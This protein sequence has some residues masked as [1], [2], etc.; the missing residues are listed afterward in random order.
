[1]I[2]KYFALYGP[3]AVKVLIIRFNLLVTF[4]SV[5]TYFID[6]RSCLSSKEGISKEIPPRDGSGL[7]FK[8][9]RPE[10]YAEYLVI[11]GK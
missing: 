1:M 11:I 7:I 5:C 10:A 4:K 8:G 2:C 9:L 6:Q 3:W